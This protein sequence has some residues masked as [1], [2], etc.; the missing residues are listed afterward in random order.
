MQAPLYADVTVL[1]SDAGGLDLEITTPLE[2]DTV[3]V[4]GRDYV[5]LGVEDWPETTTPGQPAVPF[6][7]VPLVVPPSGAVH[8]MVG[9][10]ADTTAH[11]GSIVPAVPDQPLGADGASYATDL[12]DEQTGETVSVHVLGTARDVRMARLIV[13]P[14][15]VHGNTVT[16]A[17]R[18]QVRV[19][20]TSPPLSRMSRSAGASAMAHPAACAVNADRIAA[21]RIPRSL[22][23]PAAA[24]DLPTEPCMRF[25][26]LHEGIYR[27]TGEKLREWGAEAGIDLAT[28]DPRTFRLE[29]RGRT[30]PIYVDGEERGVVDEQLA[31]EFYAKPNTEFYRSVAPDSYQDPFV[32]PGI[33]WLSWGGPPGARFAEEPATLDVDPELASQAFAYRYTVHAEEDNQYFRLDES[34]GDFAD[35]YFWRSAFSGT[36]ELF[37]IEIE[38]PGPASTTG[39]KVEVMARGATRTEHRVEFRLGGT[40]L[41]VAGVNEKISDSELIHFTRL[42]DPDRFRLSHGTV[43]LEVIAGNPDRPDLATGDAVLLNWLEVTYDRLYHTDRNYLVFQR[44]AETSSDIVDFTVTGFDTP[45]IS[46]YKLGISKL[47]DYRV[48]QTSLKAPIGGGKY[49]VRFQDSVGTGDPVYIA[50][51]DDRKLEPA[52]VEIALPWQR[53]LYDR[54]T[55]CDYMIIAHPRW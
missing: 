30:A 32:T 45:D 54:T 47:T 22:E 19:R 1:Y 7:V 49:E 28:V 6:L 53:S 42:T 38:H 25:Y 29:H 12:S 51:T 17:T 14:V 21:F 18:L 11:L 26:I 41:G 8:A 39:A 24:Q 13:R 15:R 4:E 46:V 20:F 23:R 33:Y 3:S 9:M 44:P 16:W 43:R 55:Q 10:R 48:S 31:I 36:G 35:H 40:S 50:L 5:R 34:V 27:V 2:A 52:E 37:D